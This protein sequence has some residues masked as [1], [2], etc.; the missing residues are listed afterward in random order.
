MQRFRRMRVSGGV[1]NPMVSISDPSRSLAPDDARAAVSE[2][3]Q[4]HWVGL[5]RLAV[6]VIDERQ[7][8]ALV[9]LFLDLH[10]TSESQN[11][12]AP[13]VLGRGAF[14][15]VAAALQDK[16]G[17]VGGREQPALGGTGDPAERV[18]QRHVREDHEI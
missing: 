4:R 18:G 6:L 16:V 15:E 5:V 1:T 9:L 14:V 11:G 8:A 12:L 2:L 10:G 17:A 13:G 3:Y 7:A